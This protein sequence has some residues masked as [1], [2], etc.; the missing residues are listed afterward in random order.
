MAKSKNSATSSKK[1]AKSPASKKTG[2]RQSYS[3]LH[4]QKRPQLTWKPEEYSIRALGNRAMKELTKEYSRIRSI[5][6]KRYERLVKN[7]PRKVPDVFE[8]WVRLGGL[9]ITTEIAK[10]K[11]R[12]INLLHMAARLI[13]LDTTTIKGADERV[14]KYIEHMHDLGYEFVSSKNA[15][16]F[17]RFMK[18]ARES[19]LFT[20]YDSDKVVEF[21]EEEITD[22][23]VVGTGDLKAAF[24]TWYKSQTG[25]DKFRSKYT[26]KKKRSSATMS[27]D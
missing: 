17:M 3:W 27:L 8:N 15:L 24:E 18:E 12:L 16:D 10:D 9:D 14:S 11:H 1:G 19:G 6:R 13:K 20:L 4:R 21:Y 2:K 7:D 25:S 22:R 5:L 23:D 26:S